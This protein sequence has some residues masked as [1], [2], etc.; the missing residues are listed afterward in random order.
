[1]EAEPRAACNSVPPNFASKTQEISSSS[2]LERSS[3][4]HADN[5]VVSSLTPKVTVCVILGGQKPGQLKAIDIRL[6]P[7]RKAAEHSCLA[8]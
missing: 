3:C 8:L 4:K 1:M 2:E 7:C 5:E 6:R